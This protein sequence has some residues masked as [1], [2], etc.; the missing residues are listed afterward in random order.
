MKPPRRRRPRLQQSSGSTTARTALSAVRKITGRFEIS[1]DRAAVQ[2]R[3]E[4]E[5]G[6]T[7]E[8]IGEIAQRFKEISSD[9]AAPQ[10]RTEDEHGVVSE[11]IRKITSRFEEISKDRA[12][13]HLGPEIGDI[14][15][16]RDSWRRLTSHLLDESLVFG[17]IKE[18]ERTIE[19][20][21][22]FSQGSGTQVLPIV[23]MGGIGKSTV[24]QMVYNDDRVQDRFD[25]HG[26]VHVSQ[27]FDL[28]KLTNAVTESLTRKQCE[29][30]EL[31]CVH[32]VLKEEINAKDV[33]LVLDDLWNEQKNLWFELLHPLK[34]AQSV[35]ILVT[36]RSKVVACLVQS[37]EHLVLGILPEDH[38]WLLFQHYAFGNKIFDEGS[39]LV[40]VGRKIMQKCGGL[41]LA[42]K[43]IGCLLRLKMDVQTWME[44]WK[45]SFGKV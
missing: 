9:G 26:W 11:R 32:D 7:S 30:S 6:G 37:V 45:V 16:G 39:T 34:D 12:A 38:C 2:L 28:L 40:Q 17:R 35:T 23:G 22:S 33:F 42:V 41:P 15:S 36:T 25:L 14:I 18:K 13:L 31:S 21:L 20:V 19:S 5:D 43:S 8:H 24:A 3:P 27:T 29:F 4:E 1:A 10:L 44:N